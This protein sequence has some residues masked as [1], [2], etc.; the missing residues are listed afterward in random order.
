MRIGTLGIVLSLATLAASPLAGCSNAQPGETAAAEPTDSPFPKSAAGDDLRS[1]TDQ[2]DA[3]TAERR[4]LSARESARPRREPRV[5]E[6]PPEAIGNLDPREEALV[7]QIGP[8]AELASPQ[9]ASTT[10]PASPTTAAHAAAEPGKTSESPTQ[11]RERLIRELSATL[12]EQ[13]D[14]PGSALDQPLREL[15]AAAPGMSVDDL[16]S[17]AAALDRQ[18]VALRQQKGLRLNHAALAQ[19]VTGFGQLV[20]FKGTTFLAGRAQPALVYVEVENFTHKPVEEET[21][22]SDAEP[23]WLVDLSQELQLYHD[24]DGV[25]AWHSREQPARDISTRQRRDHYLVQRITIPATLTVGAYRLK[26]IV[27]D[28]ATGAS[29]E[30]IIPLQIVADP[31]LTNR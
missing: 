14:R 16:A 21:L 15:L 8:P 29:A 1:L 28:H 5:F 4:P 2:I 22:P 27:R 24:A 6:A 11:R 7:A 25:L 3:Q 31:N 12:A 26:V 9:P 10:S 23:R 13:A 18:A 30:T 17:A 19:K 20:P